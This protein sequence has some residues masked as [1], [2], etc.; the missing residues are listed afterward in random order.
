MKKYAWYFLVIMAFTSCKNKLSDSTAANSTEEAV[1]TETAA[2]TD[3]RYELKSGI[4]ETETVMPGGMGT[5]VMKLIF[6]DYGKKKKTEITTAMSFAGKGMNTVSSTLL[7]DNYIYAW[8][9]EMKTGTKMQYDPSAVD[10]RKDMDFS[11]MTDELRQ[12]YNYKEEGEETING[13]SCK[14]YSYSVEEMSGKVWLW[15]QIPLKMEME[16]G[17]QKIL[18]NFKSI[19]ENVNIPAESFQIPSDID[20]KEISLPAT[21]VH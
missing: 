1:T 18:T 15:K 5:S 17:G 13:K 16:V 20:F 12:K 7:L 11:K 9:S 19:Q 21:A 3:G 2:P 6:D 14:V 8:S 4:V 10:L